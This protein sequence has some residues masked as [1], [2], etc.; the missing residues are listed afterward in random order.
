MDSCDEETNGFSL[1]NSKD[2]KYGT[3][4]VHN[5]ENEDV[6]NIVDKPIDPGIDD[7]SGVMEPLFLYWV[8][9]K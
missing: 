7:M 1:S 2:G 8:T 3:D 6:V 9:N 4:G 5:S